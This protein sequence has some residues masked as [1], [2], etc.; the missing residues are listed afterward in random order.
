MKLLPALI[1]ERN[2]L[3]NSGWLGLKGLKKVF[4][5]R[6]TR[7]LWRFWFKNE[8]RKTGFPEGNF[9]LTPGNSRLTRGSE[10]GLDGRLVRK[11]MSESRM[12]SINE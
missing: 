12:R 8:G 1:L 11:E 9:F 2:K 3:Q 7:T 4:Q 10:G 5:R 6:P